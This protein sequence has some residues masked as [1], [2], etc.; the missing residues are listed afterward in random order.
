MCVR[1]LTLRRILVTI[2]AVAVCVCVC[3]CVALVTLHAK[4]MRIIILSFVA[5]LYHNF[6]HYHKSG[7]ILGG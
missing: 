4:R 2:V 5:C 7:T 1:A 3:V 6:L